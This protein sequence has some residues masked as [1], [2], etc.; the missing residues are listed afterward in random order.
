MPLQGKKEC[1]SPC[2]NNANMAGRCWEP[3]GSF[4]FGFCHFEV[5]I[6]NGSDWSMRSLFC[7]HLLLWRDSALPWPIGL[8]QKLSFLRFLLSP[9]VMICREQKNKMTDTGNKISFVLRLAGWGAPSSLRWTGLNG[10]VII[11][12]SWSGFK[13]ISVHYKVLSYSLSVMMTKAEGVRA[14]LFRL[15]PLLN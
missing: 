2:L 9:A 8:E 4:W 7:I 5:F 14:S 3:C 15:I 11:K 6:M 1:P 13:G 12:M 10:L